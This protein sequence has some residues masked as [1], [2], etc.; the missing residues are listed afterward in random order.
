MMAKLVGLGSLVVAWGKQHQADEL[1]S[2]ASLVEPP[3]M[4]PAPGSGIGEDDFRERSTSCHV[5]SLVSDR[6]PRA[7]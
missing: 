6:G 7:K 1:E 2:Y 4:R 5:D 3:A